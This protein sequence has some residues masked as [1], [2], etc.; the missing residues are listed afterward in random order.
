MEC[1]SRKAAAISVETQEQSSGPKKRFAFLEEPLCSA[2]FQE[3]FEEKVKM[4]IE[5]YDLLATGE[6]VAVACSGGKDST[7]VL[8]LLR[9]FGFDVTAVAVDEGIAGYRDATL[10]D[11]GD[12]C[13]LNSVPLKVYSYKEAFGFTLDEFVSKKGVKSPCRS[14][15]ILRRYLTNRA[16]RDFDVLVTGHNLDDET[17][18]IMMN[19]LNS[20]LKIA[21]RI[22]PQ[23]GVANDGKFTKRV[24]P[25][26]FCHEKE[27]AAY[28]FVKGFGIRF[29]EC[30]NAK[31]SYRNNIRDMLNR[32]EGLY[33][34]A[35]RRVAEFL[36][37]RLHILKAA[38]GN[39]QFSYC[40]L[41]SEPSEK[42]VCGACSTKKT[43]VA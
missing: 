30:P 6:K 13:S 19:L 4:T 22:G 42:E 40:A 9:K 14:C 8:Y 15:G 21:A 38:Q 27:V 10:E 18:S 33:P 11:L 31:F 3:F 5:K 43:F 32:F 24:K 2:H 28:A 41:C 23:T 39:A 12:F 37:D 17:Q 36:L 20:N 34:G 1:F 16:A 29:I 25:L 7:V 35:K 26:Y